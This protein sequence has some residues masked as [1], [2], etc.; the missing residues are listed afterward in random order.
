MSAR[1]LAPLLCAVL[2]FTL[3]LPVSPAAAQSSL[4]FTR[5][6]SA[7]GL[8]HDLVNCL[9]QD[10]TGYLWFGTQRGLARYDGYT[11]T[12]F[13]HRR[14]D[15]DSLVNDTVA[16]LFEDGR[17]RLWVGT[18]SGLDHY[19]PAAGRFVHHPE[20]YES[21]RAFAAD[22]AGN[23]W[24][25]SAGSGLFRY[26][27]ASETF[28][29][30]LNDPT[31]PASLPDNHINA[32]LFDPEG[33]LWIGTEYGGLATL[34]P[35][36]GRFASYPDP[37]PGAPALS[38]VAAL[39]L[40]PDGSLWVGG[41][42]YHRPESGGLAR[43]D[44]ARRAYREFYEPLRGQQVTALLWDGASLWLGSA[45]GLHRLDPAYLRL[46]TYRRDPLDPFSLG[47][48]AVNALALDRSGNL[49]IATGGGVSQYARA[50]LR[51]DHYA[52][53]P[54]DPNSL[55]AAAV[56][57]VLKDD[58]GFI[59]VGLH[60]GG[61]DRLDRRT[62]QVT[63]FR[64]DPADP[65][66]LSHDHVT[67][68]YADSRRNL[69]IGTQAGLDR[70]DRR[71]DRFDHFTWEGGGAVKAI[72]E[73]ADGALW[74]GTEDPG[75]LLRLDP[76]S[77]SL[78]RYAFR[79]EAD[80]FPNTYGVRALLADRSGALWL[81]TYN[82]LVRFD[83]QS[84]TFTSYRADPA[85][86][87]S[88]SH[89][90]VW[91]LHEDAAGRLWVGTHAGLNR[92]DWRCGQ[93]A[94]CP[95]AFTV[96]TVENGLPDDSIVAIL[97][98]ERGELWL[99]TMGGGL[100][101]FDPESGAVRAYTPADGLQS[102]AFIIG[103]AWRAADGEM[104]FGGVN[105]FNAF[106]PQR[107]AANP[108]PP[109]VVLTAFR[110]FDR[111]RLF[112]GGLR[113]GMEIRLTHEENF[114]A[115]EFAALDFTDP[116]R[117]RYAYRLEGFD[118]GWIDCGTRR[119]A[120][121]TNLPPGRYVFHL[122]AANSDGVWNEQ[123]LAVTVVIEPAFWQTWWFRLLAGLA[124]FGL[125]AV[126]LGGRMRSLAALRES[127][128]RFRALFENAPLGVCEADFSREPPIARHLNPRWA[129]WFGVG[130]AFQP[131]ETVGRAFQPVE[132]AGRAF[133]PVET[134]GTAPKGTALTSCL[135][136]EALT[137]CRLAL[138]AGETVAF[139]SVGR[140]ADGSQ[141]PLR[142]SAASA[143]P[144]DLRRVILAVEDITAEKARRSEEQAIAEERRRIAGEIHDGLAQDLAALRLQVRTWQA[145]IDR[146]PQQ[147][148]AELD[149]LH[150][151]L[152]EKIREVRRVLFA[153]RPVALEE[154]GFWGA[155]EQ[156]L[157]E[158]GEQNGLAVSLEVT[159]ERGRLP[160]A[161]EPT[162]FRIVQEALHNA[163]K[164]ARARAVW[165]TIDLSGGISLSVRDDGLGFDPADLPR[166][167]RAGHLGLRQMRERV[168]ARGG[169]FAVRTAPGAGTE[170]RAEF[171]SLL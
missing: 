139:E 76:S 96:F 117:N 143:P 90:F 27:P 47:N 145:L 105:G 39:A 25:G 23:L 81:G 122:K 142:L 132:T 12:V 85:D 115:F 14:S 5:L 7:D 83:P 137:R 71:A 121:Y 129:Q 102:N 103:A 127:E 111:P 64:H 70:L 168:E 66:S 108:V 89:D 68:L 29:Q 152:G 67:A 80:G 165:V 113:D 98:D 1:R 24:I 57:A 28:T 144:G 13:R 84:E 74:I 99:A 86:P 41:G 148:K 154:L 140:R 164:H 151:L 46:E 159:G 125:A 88:L 101:A 158:F 128:A 40:A 106:Y 21:V 171:K 79:G 92:L 59:W 95:P 162:L 77:G 34:D 100:A 69:W 72:L 33:T 155:L 157:A 42:D 38:R 153:L 19:D 52:P 138:A 146:D 161:L 94:A 126:Y 120:S 3:L 16:A 65:T 56:G 48:D 123:G 9:L 150:H 78:T 44:R 2:A 82:G 133:Q 141:F 109:P 135:P 87:Q 18:V 45:A 118:P 156:F 116:A 11:F 60:D 53:R 97:G 26:D 10:S 15:P 43:F 20:V 104:F 166:L 17:G 54:G 149:G 63:H 8:P 75:A 91:S 107:I 31:D 170:V 73:T 30:F 55:A 6:T 169:R 35:R 49:W 50:R 62:G 124:V 61:L 130:Q 134:E 32:L 4:R 119:Y 114:F 163:A 93:A 160:A 51:F 22:A 110:V 36:S 37:P 58:E 167:A 131:V 147:A 112:E 136:A